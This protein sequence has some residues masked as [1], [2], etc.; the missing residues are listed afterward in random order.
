VYCAREVRSCLIEV[1]GDVYS[2]LG[3]LTKC[4]IKLRGTLLAMCVSYLN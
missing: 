3:Y 1:C 4:K 2:G